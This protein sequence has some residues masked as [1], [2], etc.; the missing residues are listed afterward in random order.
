[1]TDFLL[2]L[3]ITALGMGLVFGAIL[4]LWLMMVL[5]T[6]FTAEKESASLPAPEPAPVP[7]EDFKAQ[8]AA[9]AV[10]IALADQGQSTARPLAEPPTTIVSAWQLGM[11]T[12]QMSEK[13]NSR[14][15]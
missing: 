5:L 2:S 10:A 12:R 15:H 7:L 3:Q 6:L 8:A 4:L 14:R 9:I 1:M 13:G 11:R